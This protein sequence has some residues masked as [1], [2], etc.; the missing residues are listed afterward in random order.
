MR[1]LD[2]GELESMMAEAKI[3]ERAKR[4][5]RKVL[6]ERHAHGGEPSGGGTTGRTKGHGAPRQ[7]LT[8]TPSF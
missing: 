4:K 1:S 3:G 8:P 5:M 7:D 6:E 2:R